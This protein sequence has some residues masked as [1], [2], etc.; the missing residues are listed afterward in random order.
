MQLLPRAAAALLLFLTAFTSLCCDREANQLAATASWPHR[1]GIERKSLLSHFQAIRGGRREVQYDYEES[2]DTG[3]G[4]G[5]SDDAANNGNERLDKNWRD[6]NR[7]VDAT[8]DELMREKLKPTDP[9]QATIFDEDDP[10]DEQGIR[11]SLGNK[12]TMQQPTLSGD[13]EAM[14][15]LLR[16][17]TLPSGGRRRAS[18]GRTPESASDGAYD[19][20][21]RRNK[22]RQGGDHRMAG[23]RTTERRKG[24][25]NESLWAFFSSEP[26][27]EMEPEPSSGT[28]PPLP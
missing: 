4:G 9:G 6:A 11:Q 21:P 5:Y 27:S 7:D 24:G 25:D 2:E 12:T 16:N 10:F 22:H 15:Q 1:A 17:S 18:W 23:P 14:L 13:V 3:G 8:A 26:D 20:A 28:C 19:A